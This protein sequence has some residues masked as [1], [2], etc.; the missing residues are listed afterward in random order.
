MPTFKA[1]DYPDFKMLRV[2]CDCLTPEHTIDIMV[3]KEHP[4]TEITLTVNAEFEPHWWCRIR[5]AFKCLIGKPVY[6][7][8]V[9]LTPKEIRDIIAFVKENTHE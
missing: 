8:G 6:C 2:A 5:N 9:V 1:L 3:D 4:F 7:G